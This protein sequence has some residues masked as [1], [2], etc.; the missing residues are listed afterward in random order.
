MIGI[1]CYILTRLTKAITFIHSKLG[2]LK[3]NMNSG[4]K[5]DYYVDPFTGQTFWF[6]SD[7]DQTTL[8]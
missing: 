5:W 3:V 6:Q 2:S 1:I 4:I 8:Q 7:P